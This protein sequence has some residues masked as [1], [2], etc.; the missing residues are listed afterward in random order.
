MLARL[1][2]NAGPS[3]DGGLNLMRMIA[4]AKAQ[5][6]KP[7]E[8]YFRNKSWLFARHFQEQRADK[9]ERRVGDS[10]STSRTSYSGFAD[11]L[12]VAIIAVAVR[13]YL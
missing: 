7:A 8:C 6:G 1:F 3:L 12:Y 9:R 2:H 4:R 10:P 13:C 11:T 5:C